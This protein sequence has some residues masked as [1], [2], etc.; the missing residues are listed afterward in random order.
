M[1]S[2]EASILKVLLLLWYNNLKI[3]IHIWVTLKNQHSCECEVIPWANVAVYCCCNYR[4]FV[5]RS[6]L[7]F[8]FISRKYYVYLTS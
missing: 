5:L 3:H 8:H 6:G 1:A 7:D 2:K 4:Y